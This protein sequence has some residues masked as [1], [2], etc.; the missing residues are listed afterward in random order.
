MTSIKVNNVNIY[1]DNDIKDFVSILNLGPDLKAKNT[2]IVFVLLTETEI[3]SMFG[4]I[5]SLAKTYRSIGVHVEY[6]PLE[7]RYTLQYNLMHYMVK[8]L[9]VFLKFGNS[10]LLHCSPSKK[11]SNLVI[12]STLVYLGMGIEAILGFMEKKLSITT[13]VELKSYISEF[14]SCMKGINKNDVERRPAEV[15]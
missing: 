12:A 11:R 5:E 10:V 6:Y 3:K 4:S 14:Q 2:R 13:N 8:K 7:D 15:S 1:V 9:S